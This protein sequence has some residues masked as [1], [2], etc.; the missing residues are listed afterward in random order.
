MNTET[1]GSFRVEFLHD[2]EGKML[3]GDSLF[4]NVYDFWCL[5]CSG[6]WLSTYELKV[7]KLEEVLKKKWRRMKDLPLINVLIRKIKEGDEAFNP[8]E[9]LEDQ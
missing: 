8:T 2:E 1:Y 4:L 5:H 3:K 9:Y 7:I 6:F